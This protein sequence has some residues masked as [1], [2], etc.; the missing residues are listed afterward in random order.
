ME[1]QR[2]RL[3]GLHSGQIVSAQLAVLLVVATA[4][5]GV[6]PLWLATAPVAAVLAVLALG[7][8]R[9]RWLYQWLA[10]GLRYRSRSR[11]LPAGAE[12][13]ALLTLLDPS[14][15]VS[16]VDA[17]TGEYGVISDADGLVAVLELGEHGALLCDDTPLVPPLAALLPPEAPDTPSVVIQILVAGMPA[18]ALSAAAGVP[19][20]SYRQLSDAAVPARA[21]T[22]LAV[23]VRRDDAGWTDDDLHRCLASTLRR[24]QRRLRQDAVPAR[25]LGP[26]AIPVVLADLAQYD[27]AQPV[28]EAWPALGTGPLRQAT[29]TLRRWPDLTGTHAATLI[30]RLLA[31]PAVA[32]TVAL[33]AGTGGADLAIRLAAPDGA[34]LALA[35]QALRRLLDA[36][37]ASAT[38]CDGEHLAGLAATLPLAHPPRPDASPASASASASAARPDASSTTAVAPTAGAA[39][40]DPDQP[41]LVTGP[42]PVSCAGLMLG[43]NRHGRPVT[44]RLPRAEPTRAVLVGGVAVAALVTVRAMALGARVVVQTGRPAAWEPVLRGVST[45]ADAIMLVPPGRPVGLPPGSALVPQFVVLDVG[46]VLGDAPVPPGPWGTTLV[47][48]ED[49]ATADMDLLGRADVVILQPLSPAEAE[50]AGVALGLGDGQ[51][52]LARIRADMVGVVS[53]RTVRW[54]L[55]TPTAIEAQVIGPL[56]RATA[57]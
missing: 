2:G 12:P 22:L 7:R 9:R 19:A 23:R 10:A 56:E 4:V 54:A 53:R 18:P 29:F 45:P 6:A 30:A 20:T 16:A 40:P 14:A 31:L 38:R 8:L 25:P 50:L 11:E 44:V 28:R 34:P 47:L 36:I 51:E 33:T 21:R 27:P 39:R 55:L 41:A 17:A 37:G 3:W 49:L 13:A 52:W 57:G 5:A 1:A 26:R 48:R 15:R 42:T 35:T 46:P 43:R 32:T 24:V